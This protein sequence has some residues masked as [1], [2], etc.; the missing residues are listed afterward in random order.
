MSTIGHETTFNRFQGEA[1]DN[2]QEILHKEAS[3][4]YS[5]KSVYLGL[6]IF[7]VEGYQVIAE[8]Q[9]DAEEIYKIATKQEWI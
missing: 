6:G 4:F 5:H 8:N 9:Q 7:R 3:L 2:L 1:K